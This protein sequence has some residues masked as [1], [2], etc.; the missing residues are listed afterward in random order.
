M[1]DQFTTSNKPLILSATAHY[2]KFAADVLGALGKGPVCNDPLMLMK[3][4]HRLEPRPAMHKRLEDDVR[5][6]EIHKNV[7]QGSVE[8]IKTTLETFLGSPR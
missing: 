8:A 3:E 2:S 7:C 5:K 4:L 1:A 6:P